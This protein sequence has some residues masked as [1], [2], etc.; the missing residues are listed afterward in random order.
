[1]VPLKVL[2]TCVTDTGIVIALAPK[3]FDTSK[4]LPGPPG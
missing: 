1:M 2:L 3:S 4:Q